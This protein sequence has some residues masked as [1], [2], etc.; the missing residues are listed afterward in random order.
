MTF[1]FTPRRMR[2][3]TAAAYMDVSEQTFLDR[4]K[5]GAYPAGIRDGGVRVWLR[6]DLDA[7]IDRQF[8]VVAGRDADPFAAR[9]AKAG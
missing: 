8:G 1:A 3:V 4:V 2:A 5:A 7:L 9:F 6:D